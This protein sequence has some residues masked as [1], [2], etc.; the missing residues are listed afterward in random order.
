MCVWID[1][2]NSPH[3]HFFAPIV[4]SLRA[5]GVD[6]MITARH[7]GQ[8]EELAL[9]Y[10]MD[11]VTIGSHRTPRYMSTRV[12][13]TCMRAGQLFIHGR[14]LRPTAAL[15]HGSRALIMAAR[16]M[17]IP[18]MTTFDYEFTANVFATKISQKVLVPLEIPL[19]VLRDRGYSPDKFVR[20][21]GFKEEVYIYDFQPDP[22]ILSKLGLDPDRLIV[23]MRPPA[24]WAHYHDPLSDRLLRATVARL[25]KEND[26]QVITIAR[27]PHQAQVLQTMYHMDSRPFRVLSTAVDALSLMWYSDAV[28]SGGGTMVRE[29]AL[30]GVRTYSIFGGKLG[31]A[32]L[33]LIREGKLTAF[34]DPQQLESLHLDKHTRPPVPASANTRTRDFIVNE[35]ISFAKAADAI[36]RQ[37]YPDK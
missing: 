16:M 33:A 30:M 14:R 23:T 26:A 27:T 36:S 12:A 31:A 22:T 10:G 25:R 15:N 8:T 11:F 19:E 6:V 18:I 29:A 5:R 2:D 17:R 28:F 32:D 21:P 4:R 20:Y 24:T 35:F 7:F 37:A 1:L 3:V 34:R 13:A 9:S